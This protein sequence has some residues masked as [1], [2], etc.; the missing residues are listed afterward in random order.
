MPLGPWSAFSAFC[1]S[2]MAEALSNLHTFAVIVPNHSGDDIYRFEDRPASRAEHVLRQIIG[3][4]NFDTGGD[5]NDFAHFWLNYQIEHHIWP[6]IPMRQYQIVQ[7]KV[8]A[9]CEKY[10][11]PYVQENVFTR[12]KKMLD[13]AV[14]NTTM[15]RGVRRAE[16][17]SVAV[18]AP[19][20]EAMG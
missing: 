6:D 13:I 8:R 17:P 19:P 18:E 15:P 2:V 3:S 11:I 14:G 7:P 10:G 20:V 12:V 9:L 4:V 16:Q 1:N 5:L